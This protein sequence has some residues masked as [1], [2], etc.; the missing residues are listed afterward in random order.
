MQIF[1]F[2]EALKLI[3]DN[4]KNRNTKGY[5]HGL[6]QRLDEITDILEEAR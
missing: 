6:L 5:A 1:T 4:A 2:I 3:K